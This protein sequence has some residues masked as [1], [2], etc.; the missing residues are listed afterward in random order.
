METLR[1]I[2]IISTVV[3]LLA[4]VVVELLLRRKRKDISRDRLQKEIKKSSDKALAARFNA[5][6]RGRK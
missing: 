4:F 2:L 6:R 1:I 5:L 3:V